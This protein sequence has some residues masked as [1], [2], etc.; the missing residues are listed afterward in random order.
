MRRHTTISGFL[1]L[2][3]SLLFV[4][5]VYAEGNTAY[6]SFTKSKR[7]LLQEVF[8]TSVTWEQESTI[9]RAKRLSWKEL[10]STICGIRMLQS[11]SQQGTILQMFQSSLGI[12]LSK[13]QSTPIITGCQ[14]KEMTRFQILITLEECTHPHPIRTQSVQKEKR[15][16]QYNRKYL[17]SLP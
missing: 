4:D 11:E 6:N 17:F 16:S 13:L 3:L 5:S 1:F 15:H 10:E 12:L 7:T 14:S 2:I 9:K 8:Q